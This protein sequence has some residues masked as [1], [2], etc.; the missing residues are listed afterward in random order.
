MQE[1][2]SAVRTNQ[3]SLDPPFMKLMLMVS[4]PLRITCAEGREGKRHGAAETFDF[5]KTHT[6]T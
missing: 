1:R 6:D 5:T 3:Y 2:D 4:Q